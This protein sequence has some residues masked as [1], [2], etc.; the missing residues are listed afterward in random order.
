MIAAARG[1]RAFAIPGELEARVPPEARG[2]PRDHVQLLISERAS[3]RVEHAMFVDLPGVLRRGDLLVVNDSATLPAALV[4]HRSSGESLGLHLSSQVAGS[5]WIAEPRGSVSLGERL[6]LP[7]DGEAT[8][9]APVDPTSERMWYVR[10]VVAEPA[11]E[12]LHAYGSPIR[13]RYVTSA[14]PIEAYQTI[15]SRVPGSAEMPSA[16]RPFTA[17]VAAEIAT[18]GIDIVAITLHC[19]VSSA[20]LGEPPQ[21]ERYAVSADA[22]ES[23]NRARAQGRR[24]IAVGTTVVRAI[25]SAARG[26]RAIASQG[27]TDLVVTPDRGVKLVD[28]ILTGLHEP[29][30]THLDMLAAFAPYDAL[31]A[32]YDEAIAQRYLWHE[33]GDVH[34]IV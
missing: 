19:G 12:Y 11:V 28:G 4:A 3:G 31:R 2:V 18:R 17:A 14:V 8:L 5:L 25:E 9:I 26:G 16:A 32:A 7:G 27:W 30:A 15:F 21:P 22:A 24:V 20:E 23:I 6:T 29:A 34:L 10:L 1:L 13:Y 33:F